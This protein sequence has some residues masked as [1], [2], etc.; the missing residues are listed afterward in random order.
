M[1]QTWCVVRAHSGSGGVVGDGEADTA[2]SCG[3]P[4]SVNNSAGTCTSDT[5]FGDT[6]DPP[7]WKENV[8]GNFSYNSAIMIPG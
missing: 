7:T 8:L 5:S 4:F 3:D 6:D 2:W 1:R